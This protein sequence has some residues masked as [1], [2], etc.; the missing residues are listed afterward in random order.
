[1]TSFDYQSIAR[2]AGIPEEKLRE[3]REIM[4][5]EYPGDEMMASLHVL[6]ACMA[7]RDGHVTLEAILASVRTDERRREVE[8]MFRSGADVLRDEGREEGAIHA[9]QEGIVDLVRTKFGR[10][11][12]ST[13]KVIR[14]TR[15]QNE[16]RA[17]LVRTGTAQTLQDIGIAP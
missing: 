12:R 4:E 14:A 17:L 5:A 9:L 15:D 3:I 8:I 16:L 7:D 2:D 11:P 6:R 10:V 1:M 13:A